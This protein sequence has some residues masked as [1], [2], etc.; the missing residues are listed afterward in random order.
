MGYDKSEIWKKKKKKP[1][2]SPQ[3]LLR[4]TAPDHSLLTAEEVNVYVCYIKVKARNDLGKHFKETIWFSEHAKT[5]CFSEY[6]RKCTS[7]DN[8]I[9]C[10]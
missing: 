2:S 4:W 1:G 9:I 7:L 3:I 8:F 6:K 5:L 10:C